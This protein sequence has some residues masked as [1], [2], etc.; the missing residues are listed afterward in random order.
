MVWGPFFDFLDLFG[1]LWVCVGPFSI[2]KASNHNASTRRIHPRSPEDSMNFLKIC[3]LLNSFFFLVHG[4]GRWGSYMFSIGVICSQHIQLRVQN[5]YNSTLAIS[6]SPGTS[7]ISRLSMKLMGKLCW[8]P[9]ISYLRPVSFCMSQSG[10]VTFSFYFLKNRHWCFLN[11]PFVH[12]REKTLK[13]W[14]GM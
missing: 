9:L 1:P 4:L 2:L 6:P 5:S 7:K 14:A 13:A 10:Y 12:F 8:E 3:F 11:V